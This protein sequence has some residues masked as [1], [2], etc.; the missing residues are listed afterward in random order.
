MSTTSRRGLFL[1]FEGLD[2]CGKSTQMGRLAQRLRALGE[3]VIE[4]AEP[5]GTRIGSAIRRILL[6]PDNHA[7]GATAEMLLYFAARAQ[8]IDEV[9]EPGLARGAIVISDRWTDSTWAYQGYGR[10]LGTDVV[11]A[12]DGIACRG[13]RPDLTFL[14][15]IAVD[16]GLER[17]RARNREN[18]ASGVSRDTRMDEQSRPFYQRVQEG[19]RKLAATE[20]E[21]I[22]VIDGRGS[23]EEVEARVVEAY[24][25]FR[26]GHV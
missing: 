11:H 25:N 8:N 22:A 21:R 6:D 5:G 16:A 19:Y 12:L 13:R 1:T 9:I 23:V 10:G 4:T 15:E 3:T 2:G 17:A 24:E 18:S 26:R 14:I 20:P 7:M